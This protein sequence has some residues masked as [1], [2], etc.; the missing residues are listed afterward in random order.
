M[1]F[2]CDQMLGTL[3]KWLRI[4]GFDTFYVKREMDD[5]EILKISKKENRVLITKD[6]ELIY[7]ARREQIR[8]IE[9]QEVNLDNQIKNILENVK[10]QKTSVLTR[11][12]ICNGLLSKIDKKDV[13]NK[14]PPKVFENHKDFLFCNTCKK[15]Y[16]K[17]THYKK[18]L[19]KIG[20]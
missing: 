3:A 17:G 18:M 15:V 19:E 20:L 12:L 2:L 13:K 6:K 1:K 16:W 7:N 14:A 8:V 10:F 5:S 11:C 9:L 4:Y